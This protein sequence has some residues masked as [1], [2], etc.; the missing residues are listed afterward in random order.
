VIRSLYCLAI[1]FACFAIPGTAADSKANVEKTKVALGELGE[2]IGQWN[3]A[4]ED[5]KKAVWKEVWTWGWKFPKKD[6]DV[7]GMNIEI[8]DG[9]FFTAAVITYDLDKKE[10]KIAATA[11]DGKPQ[12]FTA[13]LV[14]GKFVMER[15]DS[16][17]KDLYRMTL[18]TAA[19]GARI[20]GNYEVVTGGK[21]LGSMV[22]KQTGG[23]EGESFAGGGKKPECVVTGGAGTIGVSFG[24][25]NY[26]VCCSGCRDE[27]NA[28]PKKYVDEYEKNKKK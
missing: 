5:N 25:K 22:Y 13:K 16:A 27:F 15:I 2:F 3:M 1:A 19:Q 11:K 10:Y 26:F 24:G 23:K 17:S 14:K 6:S 20:V 4:G 21:G 9:K 7:L 28:N 18:S 8:K 12:D